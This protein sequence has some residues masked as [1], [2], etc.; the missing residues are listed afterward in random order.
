[1]VAIED[2]SGPGCVLAAET[3]V[4]AAGQVALGVFGGV[5]YVEDLSVRGF[6]SDHLVELYGL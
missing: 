1:M 4:D 5:S 3:D 2:R 6:G